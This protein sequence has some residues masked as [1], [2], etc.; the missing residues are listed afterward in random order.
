MI[1]LHYVGVQHFWIFIRGQPKSV[2]CFRVPN[3]SLPVHRKIPCYD[4][5]CFSRSLMNIQLNIR[6]SAD[7]CPFITAFALPASVSSLLRTSLWPTITAV[8]GQGRSVLIS[9]AASR[10]AGKQRTSITPTTLTIVWSC[11]LHHISTGLSIC[12]TTSLGT[13]TSAAPLTKLIAPRMFETSPLLCSSSSHTPGLNHIIPASAWVNFRCM[14]SIY[15]SPRTQPWSC[16][17]PRSEVHHGQLTIHR[18]RVFAHNKMTPTWSNCTCP[19][20]G[21]RLIIIT[22]T[23]PFSYHQVILHQSSL[24]NIISQSCTL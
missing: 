17:K 8:R 20:E 21:T 11:P 3:Q 7:G 4:L 19:K 12:K 10:F 18:M 2:T 24:Q 6:L 23:L 16:S 13:F 5:L 1:S 9:V 22:Q 14:R 15:W